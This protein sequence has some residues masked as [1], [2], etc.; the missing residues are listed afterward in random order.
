MSVLLVV[1]NEKLAALLLAGC[2]VI[3]VARYD[4]TVCFY[5]HL[6]ADDSQ[7]SIFHEAKKL[8]KGKGKIS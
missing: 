5:V 6:T 3:D 7:F 1:A 2:T 4:T 8:R